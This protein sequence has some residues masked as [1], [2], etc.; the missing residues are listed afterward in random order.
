M[1]YPIED[2]FINFWSFLAYFQAIFRKVTENGYLPS[3]KYLEA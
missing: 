3:T 2:F 1:L